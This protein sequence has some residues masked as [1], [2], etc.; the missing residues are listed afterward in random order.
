MKA[1]IGY[2]TVSMR[3]PG[4]GRSGLEAQRYHI[5]ALMTCERLS[6]VR[7]VVSGGRNSPTPARSRRF[8]SC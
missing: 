2:L 1:A 3:E 6:L 4:H 5:E 7:S 8:L